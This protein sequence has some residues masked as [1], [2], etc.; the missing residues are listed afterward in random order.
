[1]AS[2]S[3]KWGDGR[4]EQQVAVDK[5]QTDKDL[6]NDL[7]LKISAKESQVKINWHSGMMAQ[8]LYKVWPGVL[9]SKVT[10]SNPM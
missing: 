3:R 10:S 4:E 1:M 8:T 2:G 7:R 5:N 9:L 6:P